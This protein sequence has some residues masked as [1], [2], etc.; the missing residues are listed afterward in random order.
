MTKLGTKW[1]NLSQSF[2]TFS[3]EQTVWYYDGARVYFQMSDYTGDRSWDACAL[4]I[5]RQ[6]RDYVIA[7]QG[8][9]QGYRVFSRGLQMAYERTGDATYR[10]ALALLAGDV[11]YVRWKPTLDDSLI[12][13]VAYAL[14]AVV[15]AERAG[16]PRS[17]DTVRLADY[18]L[19]HFDRLFVAK[20]YTIHQTFYDGLAAEALI[21]Y[22]ELTKDPRIPPAIKPMLDWIW[23][24]GWNKSTFR[25]VYN[26]DPIG[27]TCASGC[28]VYYAELTNLVAPAFAWYWRV[29]GD[30]I[31]QNRGD[32]LFAHALDDDISWSGKLFSQNYRWSFDYIRWRTS[33]TSSSCAY[34]VTSPT[35]M[36]ATGGNATV[37]V[38]TGAGCSWSASSSDSWASIADD[39]LRSGSGSAIIQVAANTTAS[40]RTATLTV[41]KKAVKLDQLGS[42]PVLSTILLSPAAT[43]GGTATTANRVTLTSPAPA[44]GALV[45]L[46]SSNP[47]LASTPASVSVSAGATSATFSIIT[48]KVAS[49]T[50]VNITAAYAGAS[51]T[52]ALT[53]NPS[54]I[55]VLNGFSVS[56][57]SVKGGV[58]I[59]GN[60]AGI[61]A[62]AGE[63]GI[64]VTLKSSNQTAAAV[65]AQVTIPAGQ[66]FA[67]FAIRTAAVV[68][69]TPVTISAS[70]GGVTK[71]ATLTVNPAHLS[72]LTL[73]PTSILGGGSTTRNVVSLDGPA[74]SGGAAVTLTSSNS[75]LA[76]VPASITI[77]AGAVQSGEF[78]IATT[79]VT[80]TATVTISASYGG[81]TKTSVLT[82]TPSVTQDT[83]TQPALIALT[84]SSATLNGVTRTTTNRVVLSNPA[85]ATGAIV[86]LASSNE[87]ASV[88]MFVVVPPGQTSAYFTITAFPDVVTRTGNVTATYNGIS[89]SAAL[90]I[91]P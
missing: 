60:R 14:N 65:P 54:A 44:G 69:A 83:A 75:A 66:S 71:S 3:Y 59:N 1:C 74:P 56:S 47:A 19:V 39:S 49:N 86:T 41:A 68:A 29:T 64:I 52:S 6:Y 35:T 45:M 8:R 46:S 53:L 5:A 34:E 50:T 77:S 20:N 15:D 16:E 36:P 32:E 21:N 40:T 27:P 79:G 24:Y 26:P 80:A 33:E 10:Q 13:E 81:V 62:P 51:Q 61:S 38:T 23:D 84:L 25:L 37:Q 73:S 76:R 48:G 17:P 58:T 31:Y 42:T 4:N 57:A 63:S 91:T 9:L 43:T 30:S 90:T 70:S 88:P 78:T 67:E 85:P 82:L 89:K 55:P 2:G 11:G 87:A 18:L 72:G 7:Q 22:Y 28:R 12:R